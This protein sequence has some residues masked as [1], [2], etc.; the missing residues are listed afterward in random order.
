MSTRRV[1]MSAKS[2]GSTR[3]TL[4]DRFSAIRA[5]AQA[6][7]GTTGRAN[8]AAERGG[9]RRAGALNA[10]RGGGGAA[11]GGKAGGMCDLVCM[12]MCVNIMEDGGK[13]RVGVLVVGVDI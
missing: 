9:E 13:G 2:S 12:C 8:E 7:R 3:M 6:N 10:K 1:I 5:V 11:P 4:S